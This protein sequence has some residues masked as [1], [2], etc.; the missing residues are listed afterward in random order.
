VP[1]Q[2][3]RVRWPW[4]AGAG[5][6]AG[7]AAIW[8]GDVPNRYQASQR[9]KSAQI[10][11][12][13]SDFSTALRNYRDALLLRPMDFDLQRQYVDTQTRWLQTFEREF[14][15]KTPEAAY[16]TLATAPQGIEQ[17]L[18]EPQLGT[19]RKRI[20]AVTN[21][22]KQKLETDLTK[23]EDT[24]AGGEFDQAYA[25][26]KPLEKYAALL[27]DLAQRRRD[28]ELNEV[29]TTMSL[30]KE[31]IAKDEFTAAREALEGVAPRADGVAGF[32]EQLANVRRK[33]LDQHLAAVRQAADGPKPDFEAAY[34]EL[35]TTIK[36]KLPADEAAK[37]RAELQQAALDFYGTGFVG[38]ISKRDEA[39]AKTYLPGLHDY[40]GLPTGDVDLKDLVGE[41]LDF[42]A[43]VAVLQKLHLTSDPKS[44]DFRVDVH[45][46][47]ASLP[48]FKDRAPAE[49]FIADAF[50]SWSNAQ[51]AA[52]RPAL[53]HALYLKS[54]DYH[55]AKDDAWAAQQLAA[56]RASAKL[57]VVVH[58]AKSAAKHL[59]N[60]ALARQ[61]FERLKQITPGKAGDSWPELVFVEQAD[62]AAEAAGIDVEARGNLDDNDKEDV[63]R[64]SVRYR[65]GTR[66][67][68][69]PDYDATLEEHNES[70]R[71]LNRLAGEADELDRQ[72]EDA[73][74]NPNLTPDQ[75]TNIV[76]S[77]QASALAKRW[78]INRLKQE[79]ADLYA[80]GHAMSKTVE[81]P[82]YATE[83]YEDVVHHH[84][85]DAVW[86]ITARWSGYPLVAPA[87]VSASVARTTS[88]IRGNASHGV[89]VKR[90]QPIDLAKV[91]AEASAALVRGISK[92]NLI[93]LPE[94]TWQY[95]LARS[96]KEAMAGF[97]QLE[98]G[99]GVAKRWQD[100][101][102]TFPALGT[103]DKA[104]DETYFPPDLALND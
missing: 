64:K 61:T 85:F 13:S 9:A 71:R 8:I 51:A 97:D 5:I 36:L 92:H 90:Q 89:P 57:S 67:V 87:V 88:E 91:G 102:V 62:A 49:K 22:L 79:T 14:E 58:P 70:M 63:T 34:A 23:A 77:A 66:T 73:K 19:Y 43:F 26:L 31:F 82:T 52:H 27:P 104:L 95:V 103:L 60:A 98:L 75:R 83:S 68:R 55:G 40:A 74:N 65:S 24:H 2:R 59:Q 6:A 84:R 69:N 48:R 21:T 11:L 10:A 94:V 7:A 28:L 4:F 18:T 25:A 39:K 33:E 35:E 37:V 78:E 12:L 96:R 16:D 3:K 30:A 56:V 101:G 1:P 86:M 72:T 81:E 47:H 41:T 15:G 53:A 76:I 46:V 54:L 50:R 44:A 80:Q 45:L 38:A 99:Y 32:A 100:Q 20:A 42:D 29:A 93:S 17:L